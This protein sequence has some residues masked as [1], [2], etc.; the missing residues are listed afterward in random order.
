MKYLRACVYCGQVHEVDF[1]CKLKPKVD[2]AKYK[3]DYDKLRNKKAWARLAEAVKRDS[4]YL[5]EVCFD[6]GRLIADGLESHHI[7]KIKDNPD[8]FL[9]EQNIVC[10]CKYCHKMA[11]RGELDKDYLRELAQRRIEK[12]V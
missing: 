6:K 12:Q 10:L 3:K 5:C 4:N 9:D 8:L 11:D 2:Y 1:K 7:V